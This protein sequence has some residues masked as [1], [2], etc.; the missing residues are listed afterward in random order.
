MDPLVKLSESAPVD[1]AFTLSFMLL[2]IFCRRS[3]AN[4]G[5]GRGKDS[6]IYQ[7]LHA[8]SKM[9]TPIYLVAVHVYND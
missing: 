4:C 1:L 9:S 3:I 5:R 2:V 6:A 7:L 8:K